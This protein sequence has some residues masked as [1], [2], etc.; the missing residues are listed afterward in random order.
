MNRRF[1]IPFLLSLVLTPLFIA[2]TFAGARHS[3]P[4]ASYVAFPYAMLVYENLKHLPERF[5]VAGFVVALILLFAQLPCY[6]AVVGYAWMK[7]KSWRLIVMLS[8][9]HLL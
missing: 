9:A 4:E 1:L 8:T 6:G 7:S 5:A 2:G 3:P